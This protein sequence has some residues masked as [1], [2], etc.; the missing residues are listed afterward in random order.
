MLDWARRRVK[1]VFGVDGGRNNGGGLGLTPSDNVA[2]ALDH[3]AVAA[4][5]GV[6][7][8]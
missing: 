8:A 2:T 5:V 4:A 1:L 3:L 6:G 7:V